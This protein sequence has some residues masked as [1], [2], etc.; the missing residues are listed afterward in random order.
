MIAGT[1]D[2]RRRTYLMMPRLIRFA[3]IFPRLS[4]MLEDHCDNYL[5]ET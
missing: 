1:F 4:I 2:T 3:G 5:K